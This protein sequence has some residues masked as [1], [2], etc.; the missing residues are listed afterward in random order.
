MAIMTTLSLT[1]TGLDQLTSIILSDKGLSTSKRV[2][3]GDVEA[4]AESANGMN[5]LI[6][7]AIKATGVADDGILTGADLRDVN[8]YLRVHDSAEWMALHGDDE[9]GVE[10]GFHLVRGNGAT[11]QLFG[12]NAVNVVAD[13]IYHLGF[14]LDGDRL[15]NEDG[16]PNA[17]INVVAGWLSQLLATDLAN[18]SLSDGKAV[19]LSTTGTGLDQ[20]T[21]LI[22]VDRGLNAKISTTQIKAGAASANGMNALIVEA[23]KAM[24][25]A[26]DG[27]LSGSDVREI[28]AYLRVNHATDWVM[29]HGDDESG[30]ETGFHSVQGDGATTQMF[31][32]NAVNAVADGIY[33]LGF[34]ISG[35]H[36][37]NEDGNKNASIDDV[38]GWLNSL[39]ATDL[40]NG[41]LSNA[42]VALVGQTVNHVMTSVSAVG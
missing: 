24:G 5:T 21:D 14:A 20:I 41:S 4:G 7:N 8:T 42:N 11:T 27:S 19:D 38:A 30:V 31:N 15:L 13:G 9:G 3:A 17:N 29:L 2:A 40:A 26:N 12:K 39:L 34:M 22:L 16:N 35:N 33:H 10:T 32:K 28:N 25:V 37:L 23:I 6:I 36:F 1:H 18:G